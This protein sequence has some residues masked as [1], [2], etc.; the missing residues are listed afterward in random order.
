MARAILAQLPSLKH[1]SA[2]ILDDISVYLTA[3]R[4]ALNVDPPHKILVPAIESWLDV[5]ISMASIK[6]LSK[7]CPRERKRISRAL[8]HLRPLGCNCGAKGD[9]ES[10]LIGE[11][12]RGDPG[13][14]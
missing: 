1:N 2:A 10:H 7:C 3:V 14:W 5:K 4:S 11:H 8:E 12:L 13:G 6:S 9:K